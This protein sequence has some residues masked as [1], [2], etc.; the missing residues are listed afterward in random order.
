M[1]VYCDIDFSAQV[2]DREKDRERKKEE[3]VQVDG[4]ELIDQLYHS[5]LLSF[6]DCKYERKCATNMGESEHWMDF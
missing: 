3:C 4:N 1:R 5:T 2:D 6:S